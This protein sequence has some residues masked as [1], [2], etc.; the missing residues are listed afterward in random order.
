MMSRKEGREEA[1]KE[2]WN[3]RAYVLEHKCVTE[4][5]TDGCM[6]EKASLGFDL[7][8]GDVLLHNLV[9]AY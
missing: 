1:G 7:T 8:F 9:Q 3:N 2:I 5:N 4:G 6:G